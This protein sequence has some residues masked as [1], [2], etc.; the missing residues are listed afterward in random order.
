MGFHCW[1]TS[2][3]SRSDS[4]LLL[5]ARCRGRAWA[6]NRHV[7]QWPHRT[8]CSRR[9]LGGGAALTLHS[10]LC[11][12]GRVPTVQRL[13]TL[14]RLPSKAKKQSSLCLPWFSGTCLVASKGNYIGMAWAM[15]GNSIKQLDHLLRPCPGIW[16]GL[17][18]PWD[19][20]LV[21]SQLTLWLS[22]CSSPCTCCSYLFFGLH[23]KSCLPA[24]PELPWHRWC[25]SRQYEYPILSPFLLSLS[26][27]GCLVE[28]ILSHNQ[29]WTRAQGQCTK[30]PSRYHYSFIHSAT[31]E[32][33][34]TVCQ[35]LSGCWA[36][37]EI[38]GYVDQRGHSCLWEQVVPRE[39]ALA[40]NQQETLLW[41]AVW[42]AQWK[43]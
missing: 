28:R 5:E 20:G 25:H 10:C 39:A 40:E 14:Q 6:G 36:V 31:I 42:K 33:D 35:A 34:P 30:P 4:F 41:E 12:L 37:N 17:R 8:K 26:S 16:L 3:S 29:P 43:L 38:E 23:D 27:T 7:L 15:K 9:A 32:W 2:G 18:N 11:G 19:L 21:S 1:V 24:A 13:P 22:L